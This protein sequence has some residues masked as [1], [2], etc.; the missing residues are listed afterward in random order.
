MTLAYSWLSPDFAT[1]GQLGPD[2]VTQA[3]AA[4]MVCV[5]R[6][7]IAIPGGTGGDQNGNL[8]YPT[9]AECGALPCAAGQYVQDREITCSVCTH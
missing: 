1:A 5:D 6:D 7:A 8:W 3:A 9:E 2:D 4:E